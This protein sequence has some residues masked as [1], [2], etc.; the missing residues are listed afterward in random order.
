MASI[1]TEGATANA[2]WGKGV[3]SVPKP[4][5]EWE[6]WAAGSVGRFFL[7]LL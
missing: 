3:Y 6:T 2:W 4:P 1:R 5:D 7:V